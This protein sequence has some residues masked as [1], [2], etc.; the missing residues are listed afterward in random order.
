MS[1]VTGLL[2]IDAPASALN[3]QGSIP[4]EQYGNKVAVKVLRSGGQIY[5]Y[6]SAQAFRY[7]LRSTLDNEM[8]EWKSAPVHREENIA[9][10]D[11]NPILWH[12]DDLL[13]YMRA[14][15]G[16]REA[17]KSPSLQRLTPLETDNKG[18]EKT[19]TRVSPFRVSTLV[20]VAPVSLTEDFGV[21][22]RHEVNTEGATDEKAGPVIHAHQ[23][24]R[25][26]LKGLFSLNLHACGTF[27]YRH[28]TGFRNLDSVRLELA[29]QNGLEHLEAEKSYRLPLNERVRRIRT[30][31]DGLAHL[32]G[33]A[34]QT[35][36]YTDVSP[37][38]VILTVTRGGNHIFGHVVGSNSRGLPEIKLD[39]L[40]EALMVFADDVLSPVYF[41]WT[42]GY[43]DDE[44]VK[45]EAAL[46]PGGVLAEQAGCIQIS[47][48][49]QAFQALANDLGQA[50][51]A[52]WLA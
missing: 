19:L 40:R 18:K 16:G 1:F 49:R 44:R 33:G 13:G 35:L 3:N 46:G 45:V 9:Y 21:M 47:H 6:V 42:R 32:E 20:S 29:K 4:D 15:E 14:P 39:A 11:A 8:F 28:R 2:L 36:H 27:S 10:T 37:A 30:L 38:F 22:T 26:T 12:D 34:K 7:W 24:Y 41:G 50:E 5:P 23:V 17:K 48:P 43:L 25:T 31:L 52:S 51:N